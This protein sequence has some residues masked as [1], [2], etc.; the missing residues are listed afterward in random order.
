MK[1]RQKERRKNKNKELKAPTTLIRTPQ[2]YDTISRCWGAC[3]VVSYIVSVNIE[4]A[5]SLC[6][7]C[8]R[9]EAIKVR[10]RH[11]TSIVMISLDFIFIQDYPRIRKP[12]GVHEIVLK[13]HSPYLLLSQ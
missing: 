13:F 5:I 8:E 10:T 4:Y 11:D 2:I 3:H 9:F 1:S 7:A 6:G 12:T